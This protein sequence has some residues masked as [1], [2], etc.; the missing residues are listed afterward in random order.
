MQYIVIIVVGA[1]LV[2]GF[3][4]FTAS[5]EEA[6]MND[7]LLPE[8]GMEE[9]GEAPVVGD[10]TDTMDGTMDEETGDGTLPVDENAD[11]NEPVSEET[12]PEAAEATEHTFDIDGFNYGFSEEEIV[13]NEGDT[14]T[15]NFTSTEGLHDWVV[16][17]FNASTA[18]VG[19]G[20]S[21]SIT[22]V[23]DRAGEFEYYC[24]ISSHRQQGMVGTLIVQ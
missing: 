6:E 3:L 1:A 16:D 22:F 19:S 12:E 18:Q 2:L 4:F 21:D 23:A 5:D 8:N 15:I 20:Q 24:S 10:D 7:S 14:V 17:E 11:P 9:E 13:V